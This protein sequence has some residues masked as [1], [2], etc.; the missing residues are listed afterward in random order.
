VLDIKS[1]VLERPELRSDA[2]MLAELTGIPTVVWGFLWISAALA[3]SGTLW[4]RAF[5][6]A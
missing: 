5:R 1:D 3:V 6:A 4:L 2:F